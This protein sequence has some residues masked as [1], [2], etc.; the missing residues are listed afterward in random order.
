MNFNIYSE[1]GL[2]HFFLLDDRK[3]DVLDMHHHHHHHHNRHL[4]ISHN[5][6]FLPQK[7][8]QRSCLQFLSGLL[9]YPREIK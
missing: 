6:P 1:I 8:L 9:K 4:H 3:N 5:T 7:I 2:L